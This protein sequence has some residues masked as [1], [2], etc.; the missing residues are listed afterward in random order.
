[1]RSLCRGLL[2]RRNLSGQLILGMIFFKGVL[3]K[4]KFEARNSK[5]ETSTNSQNPNDPNEKGLS[6]ENWRFGFVSSLEIRISDL[7]KGY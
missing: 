4:N 2:S 7:A 5:F 3:R 1:L 6:F